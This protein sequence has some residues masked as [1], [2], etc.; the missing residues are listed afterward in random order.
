MPDESLQDSQVAVAEPKPVKPYTS[1][2]LM[3]AIRQGWKLTDA[4]MKEALEE[5]Y[6]VAID[7]KSER[8]RLMATQILLDAQKVL[9][10]KDEFAYK[11]LADEEKK[12]NG[13]DLEVQRITIIEVAKPEP[14]TPAPMLIE[15]QP[16][17]NGTNGSGIHYD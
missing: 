9:L 11:M 12:K 7:G 10:S 2:L 4:Q 1:R 16:S 6:N 5:T 14:K 3:R 15:I 8:N 17:V 13:S